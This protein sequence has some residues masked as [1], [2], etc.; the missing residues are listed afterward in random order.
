MRR[1]LLLA[2]TMATTALLA[3]GIAAADPLNSPN[4]QTFDLDCGG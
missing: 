1:V 4:G 3:E 2:T